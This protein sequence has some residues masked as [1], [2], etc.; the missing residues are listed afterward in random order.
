M[1]APAYV[2]LQASY[3]H[4]AGPK[5]SRVPGES[6]VRRSGRP[7]S[8]S[9]VSYE[10]F[11][12]LTTSRRGKPR[13][14]Q[15]VRLPGD[16]PKMPGKVAEHYRCH[17]DQQPSPACDYCTGAKS[18][19]TYV[20]HDGTVVPLVFEGTRR[21]NGCGRTLPLSIEFFHAEK[22]LP[23]GLRYTC[24]EC[25]SRRDRERRLADPAKDREEHL[26]RQRRRYAAARAREED[27]ARKA[28]PA[29]WRWIVSLLNRKQLRAVAEVTADD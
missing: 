22:R 3:E 17:V 13:G 9:A 23:A 27:A 5:P 29:E 19:P 8:L 24:R 2:E 7:G 25:C 26:I 15:P 16:W 21:C 14:T 6:T 4:P 1:T 12:L 18:L 10:C 28:L 11:G 20:R